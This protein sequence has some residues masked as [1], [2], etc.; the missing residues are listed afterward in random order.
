MFIV[1]EII[2]KIKNILSTDN[3]DAKIFDKDVAESLSLLKLN[4][5]N[6]EK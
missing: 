3:K 4:F 1:E 2:N 5:G 6:Y